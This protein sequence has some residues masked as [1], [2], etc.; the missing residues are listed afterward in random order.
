MAS[1][2]FFLA[3]FSGIVHNEKRLKFMHINKPLRA[4]ILPTPDICIF[5]FLSKEE[6]NKKTT[7]FFTWEG[8]PGWKAIKKITAKLVNERVCLGFDPKIWHFV[9]SMRTFLIFNFSDALFCNEMLIIYTMK[10][11]WFSKN[12]TVT[13]E[14]L[15]KWQFFLKLQDSWKTNLTVSVQAKRPDYNFFFQK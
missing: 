15:S 10:D 4:F 7:N 8:W 6:L 2:P 3:S 5:I 9:F 11:Y 13:T 1:T 12:Q 14:N